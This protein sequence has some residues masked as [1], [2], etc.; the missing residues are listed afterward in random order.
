MDQL[1]KLIGGGDI[2][3]L[4]QTLRIDRLLSQ[5]AREFAQARAQFARVEHQRQL[6]KRRI[7]PT[8]PASLLYGYRGVVLLGYGALAVTCLAV[9]T[10]A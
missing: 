3:R 1:D 8:N 7:L 6:L 4:A 5:D 2:T 10:G 9:L